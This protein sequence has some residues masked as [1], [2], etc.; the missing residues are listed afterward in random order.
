MMLRLHT[1]IHCTGFE[2]DATH[3]GS[4]FRSLVSGSAMEAASTQSC[5]LADA[6]VCHWAAG[7]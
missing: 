2:I 6:A 3:I 5:C 1:W 4:N 7:C